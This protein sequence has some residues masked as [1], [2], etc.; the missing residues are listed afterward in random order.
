M[1]T[2]YEMNEGSD[3]PKNV[4]DEL[5][6]WMLGASPELGPIR[7]NRNEKGKILC[8]YTTRPSPSDKNALENKN[9]I[10]Y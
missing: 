1:Y 8:S 7:S 3:L 4:G 9:V 2:M 10:L 6:K 5:S